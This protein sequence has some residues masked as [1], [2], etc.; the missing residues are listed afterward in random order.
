MSAQTTTRLRWHRSWVAL[1]GAIMLFVIWMALTPDPSITLSFTYGDKLLHA[2]T[3]CGLTG[4]WGNVYRS[5]RARGWI[6]LGCL[7][8][9]VFIEFAQWLDPPRDASAW[10]VAA[11]VLGILL[12]L[13]LLRTPLAR[14][15]AGI[16]ASFERRRGS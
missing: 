10:D 14:V 9:G 4:W 13:L 16:E 11:D 2:S 15:L 12:A 8:F 7:V 3:F 6:V 5:R 1:G